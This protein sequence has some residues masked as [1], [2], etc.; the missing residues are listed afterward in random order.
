MHIEFLVEEPSAEAALLNILPKILEQTTSFAIH[1]YQGKQD[2]LKK[3]PSRFGGYKAWLPKDW[4]IV[5]LIDADHED[6]RQLKAWLE[7]IA[8]NSKFVTKSVTTN[9]SHFQVLN[10]LAIEELEAWF[11]G[12]VEA[13]HATYPRISLNLGNRAKYHDPD[14]ITGG[15]W[16]A[17]E[18]ELKRVGYYSSGLSKI[19]A[20]REISL[21]MDPQRNRSHSFQVF[22]RGLLEITGS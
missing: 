19:S 15:T 17:L 16:E 3:L 14:S 6:C 20:A 2:L 11:F 12:D 18:R 5:V 9:S 7:D 8:H 22:R 21:H 4:R 1:P 13:L 10:R